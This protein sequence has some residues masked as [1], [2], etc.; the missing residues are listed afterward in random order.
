MTTKAVQ[1]TSVIMEDP[2]RQPND[3]IRIGISSCLLGEEVRFDGGH[4]H[5]RYLTGT[6][7]LLEKQNRL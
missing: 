6:L 4:K 1:V 7:N 3:P 5:D 2:S